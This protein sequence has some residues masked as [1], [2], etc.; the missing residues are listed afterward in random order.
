[1]DR[2]VTPEAIPPPPSPSVTPQPELTKLES[3]P[4]PPRA[5]GD[6]TSA[7]NASKL[8]SSQKARRQTR[9]PARCVMSRRSF[10]FGSTR[11]ARF[12]LFHRPRPPRPLLLLNNGAGPGRARGGGGGCWRTAPKESSCRTEKRRDQK[13]TGN[14]VYEGDGVGRESGGEMEPV[15]WLE[16]MAA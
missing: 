13:L 12:L 3:A 1:M 16:A 10:S 14:G 2:E 4:P 15:A 8:A 9:L 5:G 11:L 6:S 7:L